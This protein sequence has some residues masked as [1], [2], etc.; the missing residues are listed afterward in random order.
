MDWIRFKHY[1]KLST[2]QPYFI[3]NKVSNLD[4]K[5]LNED[6]NEDDLEEN[7][8]LW[9]FDSFFEAELENY[10][11]IH[12]NVFKNFT[13]YF[14]EFVKQNYQQKICV[15]SSAKTELAIEQTKNFM[16]DDSCEIILWPTFNFK[17]AISKPDVF[18]KKTKEI[19]H[20]K[21][22]SST[23]IKEFLRSHWDFWIS[24][25]SLRETLN[26]KFPIEN[27]A[28]F[29]LD[30]VEKPKAKQIEFAKLNH[31]SYN[32]TTKKPSQTEIKSGQYSTFFL[33]KIAKQ[34]GI[35]A[36]QFNDI[37]YMNANKIFT[38]VYKGSINKGWSNKNKSDIYIPMIDILD[39][40]EMIEEAKNAT[41]F[42]QP[43]AID[44]GEFAK[45]SDFNQI[46]S[47]TLPEIDGFS[48]NLIKSNI[49]IELKNKP[50]MLQN[51]INNSFWFNFFKQK[52][53]II[54]NDK[55]SIDV[56]LDKLKNSEKIVWFDFEAFS[57]PYPA[58]HFSQPYQQ[59]IFQA[60]VIVTENGKEIEQNFENRN[61]VVDPKNYKWQDCFEIIDKIYDNTADLY[62]VFNKSYEHSKLKEMLNLIHDNLSSQFEK[63]IVIEKMES[64]TRKVNEIIDKTID[65]KDPFAKGW[66][67]VSDL[68][69][70]FSIKKIENFITKYSYELTHLITPYKK[71]K[72][73]N[74]LMAM[75]KGIERYLGLIG[76]NEWV[77]VKKHLQDYC[78]NDVVAM[79]MVYD[80]LIFVIE[81]IDISENIKVQNFIPVKL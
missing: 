43:L 27:I 35:T 12:I 58:I 45:N 74:G 71:L 69:G 46:V 34:M 22:S 25:Y 55:P 51:W 31:I 44:N 11:D 18:I 65:L 68:K 6:L 5:D 19:G 53:Q 24:T 48:G 33:K 28:I 38:H 23:S 17:N 21:I 1:L 79:I 62:V 7:E 50:E 80:F 66:M 10:V 29:I 41:T 20:L 52:N 54:V 67:V 32:K 78:Q 76:D 15:V 72:V 4:K 9:N 2:S 26:I 77:G 73:Q 3:W 64:Y 60:S 61:F 42:V 47:Q 14:F 81:N 16:L 8:L 30:T 56:F 75:Q 39:A 63:H 13:N 40:L 37:N 49:I 36:K 57:L 59:L 70:F